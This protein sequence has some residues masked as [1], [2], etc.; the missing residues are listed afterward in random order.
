MNNLI[1]HLGVIIL[2]IGVILLAVPFFAKTTLSN[3]MLLIGAGVIIAGYLI[4]IYL[5]RK[6]E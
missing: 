2:L 1:K 5:N 3:T 6:A 4:H